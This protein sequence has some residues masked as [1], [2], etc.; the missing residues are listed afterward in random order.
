MNVLEIG[1]NDGLLLSLI[2]NKTKAML[3][4]VEPSTKFAAKWV[5]NGIIG[6]NKFFGSRIA[7]K[8]KQEFGEMDIIL[9]RHVLEHI[10]D[11]HDFFSGL[12]I[13][14]EKNVSIYIE[15]PYV[16]SIFSLKRFENVSYTHLIHYGIKSM[17]TLAA[18]HQFKVTD[19]WLCDIDGGSIVFI[20]QPSEKEIY[21]D[22]SFN[23]VENDLELKFNEFVESF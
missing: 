21:G 9:I 3:Y 17:V 22:S 13:I 19:Y 14:S 2:G 12:K 18:K 20:L 23:D 10:P 7:E 4:G 16:N 1:C 11:P 5:E 15:V 6:V 8:M